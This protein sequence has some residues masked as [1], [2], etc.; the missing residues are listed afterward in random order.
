F[1]PSAERAAAFFA[2]VKE[3]TPDAFPELR[4][5]PSMDESLLLRDMREFLTEYREAENIFRDGGRDK[6]HCE[7]SARLVSHL[8]L[9]KGFDAF[10]VYGSQATYSGPARLKH[11]QLA[12]IA[13][14]LG[15]RSSFAQTAVAAYREGMD[16]DRFRNELGTKGRASVNVATAYDIIS[17][18]TPNEREALISLEMEERSHF[19][20]AVRLRGAYYLIDIDGQ[21]FGRKY[22]ELRLFPADEA[23]RHN[24][25]MYM[26]PSDCLRSIPFQELIAPLGTIYREEQL[27]LAEYLKIL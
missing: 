7:W 17:R 24:Y 21:Q 26:S 19:M 9:V 3:A 15:L 18:M 10:L 2:R 12:S 6:T 20:T 1:E 27:I 14:V 25:V 5:E 23:P 11:A 8:L 4:I 16:L 13:T 22:D